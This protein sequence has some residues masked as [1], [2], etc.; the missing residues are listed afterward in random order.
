V[1]ADNEPRLLFCALYASSTQQTLLLLLKA[2]RPSLDHTPQP[3]RIDTTTYAYLG[4]IR[5][6]NPVPSPCAG[7]VPKTKMV[8]I[9]P[10]RNAIDVELVAPGK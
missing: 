3:V 6:G 10:G 1:A 5:D 8:E 2:H 7:L 9:Q 4:A